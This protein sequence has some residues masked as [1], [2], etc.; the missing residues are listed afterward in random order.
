MKSLHLRA[1][2]Q[3]YHTFQPPRTDAPLGVF[4]FDLAMVRARCSLELLSITA[5]QGF[6]LETCVVARCLVE[7]FAY[8]VYVWD[9]TE[10]VDVFESKPQSLIKR[11]V[12]VC[13][14]AGRAYGI[15]SRLSHYDPKLHYLFIGDEKGETVNHRGW[16]F[17]I[18]ATAWTFYLFHVNFLVFKNAYSSYPSFDLLAPLNNSAREAF[19]RY[20]DGVENFWVDEVRHLMSDA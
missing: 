13:P 4:A 15:L 20:F 14:S 3:F 2:D 5:R 12:S 18:I 10:D 16:R 9:K 7:Q 11:L 1:Y 6:L 17:K 19:D 8:A